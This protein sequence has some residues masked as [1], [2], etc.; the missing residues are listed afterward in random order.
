MG[1]MLSL[2]KQVRYSGRTFFKAPHAA[3]W[4]P[5]WAATTAT[6]AATTGAVVAKWP[7]VLIAFEVIRRS[8]LQPDAS[9]SVC[10]P[11]GGA[12]ASQISRH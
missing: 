4:P 10:W 1:Q 8:R 12:A 6:P 7:S 3:H 9:G 5:P 2:A 11:F